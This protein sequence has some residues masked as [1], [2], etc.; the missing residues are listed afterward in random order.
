M[1]N[2]A[3]SAI[4]PVDRTE[5]H[6]LVTNQIQHKFQSFVFQMRLSDITGRV[7]NG[8]LKAEDGVK[9]IH[10]LAAKYP[11]AVKTDLQKIF[12]AW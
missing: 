4:P 1:N 2:M 3:S 12:K 11:N 9:A 5:W 10:E 7:Q 6:Q 8:S